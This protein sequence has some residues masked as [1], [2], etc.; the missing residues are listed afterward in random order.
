M[1]W[2][3]WK[4][5]IATSIQSHTFANDGS[6]LIFQN[7]ALS[8]H[9]P[10]MPWGSWKAKI[11]TNILSYSFGEDGS[12]FIIR[13]GGQSVHTPDMPWGSWKATTPWAFLE[14]GV[15]AIKGTENN[16]TVRVGHIEGTLF[17]FI[18]AN[19]VQLAKFDKHLVQRIEYQTGDGVDFF[20][21]D[22]GI[23]SSFFGIGVDLNQSLGQLKIFGT[24]KSE[25]IQV[26]NI[27]QDIVVRFNDMIVAQFAASEV[28][29]KNIVVH[30]NGGM[31]YFRNDLMAAVDLYDVGVFLNRYQ[32]T[33]R[34]NGTNN[35]DIIQVGDIGENILV[36]FN[37]IT[38]ATLSKNEV[39][40]K[41]VEINGLDG[42]DNL[43]NDLN[44]ATVIR[45]GK[46]DDFIKSRNIGDQLHGQ[47]GNDTLK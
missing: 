18:T 45:G 37:E 33:I 16:D 14:N 13:N 5:N 27:N 4:A 41:R 2:G 43:R 39:N 30:G 31:D 15:L 20:R 7:G 40:L 32:G 6:L 1:P 24:D 3:S 28:S 17:L 10:D 12:L 34:I 47:E 22:T 44:V 8:V 9:T 19:N 23:N 29:V 11:A 26:R 38:V 36:R 42:D 35:R 25:A 46:G 21:N